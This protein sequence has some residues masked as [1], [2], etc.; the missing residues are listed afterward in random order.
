MLGVFGDFWELLC[1]RDDLA[2]SASEEPE[3]KVFMIRMLIVIWLTC[4]NSVFREAVP[5]PSVPYPRWTPSQ[6]ILFCVLYLPFTDISLLNFSLS[7]FYYVVSFPKELV[8]FIFQSSQG[9]KICSYSQNL[10][11]TTYSELKCAW[12]TYIETNVV[13]DTFTFIL[14]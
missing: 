6:S 9:L 7:N 10:W 1:L 12:Q 13:N 5:C 3:K 2:E 14:L 4:Q 8:L 11:L